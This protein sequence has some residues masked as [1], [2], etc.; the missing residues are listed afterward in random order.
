MGGFHGWYHYYLLEKLGQINYLG[1]WDTASF[2]DNMMVSNA[3][4]SKLVQTLHKSNVPQLIGYHADINF[5][6]L[7]L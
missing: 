5:Y 6:I 1:Y 7:T 3:K 2:G 4:S